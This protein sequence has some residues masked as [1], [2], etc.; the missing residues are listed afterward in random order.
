MFVPSST[1]LTRAKRWWPSAGSFLGMI[2]QK[3][4]MNQR[5]LCALLVLLALSEWSIFKK[6]K[7]KKVH[8]QFDRLSWELV[9]CPSQNSGVCLVL[10]IV[11]S[12]VEAQKAVLL[13]VW[14]CESVY[15]Q[16]DQVVPAWFCT[17]ERCLSIWR[18]GNN[19]VRGGIASGLRKWSRGSPGDNSV[20]RR[21]KN[22]H[23]SHEIIM[24]N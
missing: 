4:K 7:K 24:N 6:K 3:R 11:P 1:M 16:S 5:F 23:T 17:T 19:L 9:Q 15:L 20:L 8:C 13:S 2:R 12:D 22:N 18:Q 21:N 10:V 14:W